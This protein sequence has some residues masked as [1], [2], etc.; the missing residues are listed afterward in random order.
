MTMILLTYQWM[1]FSVDLYSVSF[2]KLGSPEPVPS[3]AVTST[4]GA[5]QYTWWNEING[6]DAQCSEILVKAVK[7]CRKHSGNGITF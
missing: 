6:P 2:W 1:T 5:Q 3:A 7:K 4:V